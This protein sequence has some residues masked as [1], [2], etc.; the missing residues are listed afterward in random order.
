MK[1]QKKIYHCNT[2]FLSTIIKVKGREMRI[3]FENGGY[4]NGTETKGTY[5]TINPEIQAA[6]ENDSRFGKT[7]KLFNTIVVGNIPDKTVPITALQVYA[8]KQ[9]EKS[10]VVISFEN[11]IDPECAVGKERGG[12]K[13]VT[14]ERHSDN[15]PITNIATLKEILSGIPY[16][17]PLS[18]LSNKKKIL[19]EATTAGIT[20]DIQ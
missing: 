18:R 19:A 13:F 8:D 10:S 4:Y 16:N 5:S 6:I 7:I 3:V 1:I 11:E 2:H 12:E 9:P 14:E 17:I 20:F 15:I